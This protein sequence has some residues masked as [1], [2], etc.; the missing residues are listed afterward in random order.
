ML[1]ANVPTVK[2]PIYTPPEQTGCTMAIDQSL[3]ILW[4]L[5]ERLRAG[6]D[7]Y[8]PIHQV[9]EIFFRELLVMGH[10]VV[11]GQNP[12]LRRAAAFL[13]ARNPRISRCFDEIGQGRSFVPKLAAFVPFHDLDFGM[14]NGMRLEAFSARFR[15]LLRA[16]RKRPRSCWR[17]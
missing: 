7:Q 5:V 2:F 8:Q 4:N 1:T 17:I 13:V 14:G 12:T 6:T 10:P 15:L 3:T 16:S 9:E 11:N